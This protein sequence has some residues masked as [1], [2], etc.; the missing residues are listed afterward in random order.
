V[1]SDPPGFHHVRHAAGGAEAVAAALRRRAGARVKVIVTV[2]EM[3][4]L[5]HNPVKRL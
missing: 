2:G 3:P 5:F 1:R 4:R